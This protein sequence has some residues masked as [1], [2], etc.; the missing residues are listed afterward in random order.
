MI[1]DEDVSFLNNLEERLKQI[2][3]RLL[4][5]KIIQGSHAG[6]IYRLECLDEEN[7]KA[8]YIY[9]EFATD[10]KNEIDIY[11]K[12]RDYINPFSKL[13][14]MWDS[15]PPAILM[16]DLQSPL[17]ERFEP[18]TTKDKKG[19]L[20]RILNRLAA[21]HSSPPF[22][23]ANELP[24]HQI[25]SEW[26]DW[27]RDQLKRLY[28]QNQWAKN[29]WIKTVEYSYSQL[30]I[31][32][33]KPRSPLVLTHG[34]PHLENIFDAGEQIW[35]IDWEWA[36]KGSPLRDITILLQD[37]YEKELV[38]FALSAYK[39]VLKSKGLI[40]HIE[41]YRQDFHYLYIDH[42]T[43]MLAWEI[44]KYF[45]GFTSKEKIREII[46]FKVGEITRVTKEEMR[47]KGKF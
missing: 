42:T 39:N 26:L 2:N 14:S 34:D 45:Q 16:H 8:S 32:N 33:Y 13:V 7:Q 10:R 3:L 20:E 37:V 22:Q 31:M 18:L 41:E 44:E 28:L 1:F 40:I 24:T 35:F 19:M 27:C 12:I 47:R 25:T 5:M 43:M 17:K 23:I 46:T 36:A 11:T 4:N 9:K 15:N 21:L 30:D 29:V 38:H 6:K